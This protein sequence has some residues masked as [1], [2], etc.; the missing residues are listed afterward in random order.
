MKDNSQFDDDYWIN[1]ID[2]PEIR[3]W[4]GYAFE[5]VCLCHLSQIKSA[6]GISSVQTQ[7][8]TWIG[9]NG[10]DKAQID[11]VIDRRDQVIN[12]CEMKFSIKAFMIDKAYAEVLRT[13]IGV[14]KDATKTPKALRLTFIS[15]HGL[16]PNSYSQSLVHLALTMDALFKINKV[17]FSFIYST[18][19]SKVF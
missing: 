10:T 1:G 19:T 18:F 16:T 8:S 12:L 13:K 9:S 5:Q 11:L 6:L 2:S 17:I 7:T 14:F 15:T 3:A 4:S